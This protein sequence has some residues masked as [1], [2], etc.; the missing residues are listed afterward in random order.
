[1]YKLKIGLQVYSQYI[2]VRSDGGRPRNMVYT[3]TFDHGEDRSIY[4]IYSPQ[5]VQM[6]A[7]LGL[8]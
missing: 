6:H 7:Q 4:C 8:S 1:M 5:L 2:E 3:L